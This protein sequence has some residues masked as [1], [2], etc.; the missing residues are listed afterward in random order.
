MVITDPIADMLVR[1]RNA[2]AAGR[3][4]ASIPHS[5]MKLR[6]VNVLLREGFVASVEKKNRA[7]KGQ[8]KW[9]EVGILYDAPRMPRI[10]GAERVS[11]PSRRVYSPSSEL[12][13]VNQGHGIAILTTPKGVM[14]DREARK[15][16]VGG[17][18]ICK[19]W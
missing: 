15:E 2:G 3:P 12:R 10:R 5:D 9:I 6:I 8:T 14:A 4:S 19:V 18:V 11:R 16:H 1:I 17:E 13:P 7:G